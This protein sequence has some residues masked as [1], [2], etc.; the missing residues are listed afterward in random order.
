M[1][2]SLVK[3]SFSRVLPGVLAAVLFLTGCASDTDTR[4]RTE[5]MMGTFVTI[6]VTPGVVRGKALDS[7]VDAAFV[8]VER[9]NGLMSTYLD[10]SE[11]SRINRLAAGDEIAVSTDMVDVL[12]K[13]V[14]L[15]RLTSGAFDVTVGPLV[16]LWG[17]GSGAETHDQAPS[18][19]E[20]KET[21]ALTGMDLIVLDTERRT[22]AVEK[23]GVYIDLSGI[24]KGYA[25]D[26]AL[27]VL[28][29][30]GVEHALVNAGGDV[31][32]LGGKTDEL[33]WTVGVQR[34]VRDA[35]IRATDIIGTTPLISGAIATSGTYEQYVTVDGTE[36]SHIID[37]RTGVPRQ[38]IPSAT[39]IAPDCTTADALATGLLVLGPEE[40]IAVVETMDGVEALLLSDENGSLRAW[41]SSGWTAELSINNEQEGG[42]P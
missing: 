21:M 20:M 15:N 31:A 36:Y 13:A 24:A 30:A 9:I 39:V 29:N 4:V 28:K 25:V 11:I 22:V 33:A 5:S 17:F 16:S 26:R 38:N 42:Q 27:A 40:G 1:R 3:N 6:S 34:P 10:D 7:A 37:P 23:A 18:G 35:G 14:E 32:A 12:G 19:I 8:E 41:K 2:M